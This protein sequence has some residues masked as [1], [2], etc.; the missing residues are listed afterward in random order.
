MI[1]DSLALAFPEITLHVMALFSA[2][3]Q[4]KDKTLGR[5]YKGFN[6]N[7]LGLLPGSLF[8][9]VTHFSFESTPSSILTLAESESIMILKLFLISLSLSL[10]FSL[11]LSLTYLLFRP[12]RVSGEAGGTRRVRGLFATST[13]GNPC[14][15]PTTNLGTLASPTV[16]R[17]RIARP[18]GR[19][20]G[21]SVSWECEYVFVYFFRLA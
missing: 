2:R 18:S 15:R 9:T 21:Y 19:R 4:S 1:Y 3:I 13:T 17:S 11:S 7:R 12:Q 5:G 16:T 14:W 6:Q 20:G 8:C 10:S